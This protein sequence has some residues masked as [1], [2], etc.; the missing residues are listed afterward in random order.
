MV[1]KYAEG[2]FLLLNYRIVELKKR[3]DERVAITIC[4][5]GGVRGRKWL[6][7]YLLVCDNCII[8]IR[9]VQ[10]QGRIFCGMLSLGLAYREPWI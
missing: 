10:C 2:L 5:K 1:R 3:R 6:L 9:V 4:S 8:W 7:C